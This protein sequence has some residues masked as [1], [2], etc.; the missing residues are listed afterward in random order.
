MGISNDFQFSQ[1]SLQDYVDCPR[2]FFYRYVERL[3]WPALEAEPALANEQWMQHGTDFHRMVH[4]FLLGIPEDRLTPGAGGNLA[5]WWK[6]FIE[7]IP[8]DRES[9]LF[10][11]L[12]L[13]TELDG[14]RLVAKIDLLEVH[15][16]GSVNIYDWKTSRKVPGRSHLQQR[17]QTTVYPYVL[18]RSPQM[19]GLDQLPPGKIRMVYWYAVAPEKPVGFD[20]SQKQLEADGETLSKVIE[21]ITGFETADHF[22]LT[23]DEE[24]CKFCVYR[25]LCAR[26][27]AAGNFEEAAPEIDPEFDLDFDLIEEIEF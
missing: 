2:R 8:F 11:E 18:A 21:E 14:R 20:Y 3:A 6:D 5:A 16:D 15:K 1:A 26:G 9:D 12:M 27:E 23:V 10:P 17:L 4:R 25:S 19:I 24:R 13:V 7:N 22:P